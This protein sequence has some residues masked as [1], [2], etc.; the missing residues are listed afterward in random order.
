MLITNLPKLRNYVMVLSASTHYVH[1]IS[2][3]THESRFLWFSLADSPILHNDN[4][5]GGVTTR[6][7]GRPGGI[8]KTDAD[9]GVNRHL[10]RPLI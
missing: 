4:I 10:T 5:R 7:G 9:G 3:A 2:G 8:E 6:I 1:T